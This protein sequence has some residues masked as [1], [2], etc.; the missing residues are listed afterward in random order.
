MESLTNHATH[1]FYFFISA[2]NTHRQYIKIYAQ[3]QT[4]GNFPICEIQFYT[5]IL[6]TM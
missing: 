4:L 2:L 6:V 1:F 3:Q 5:I